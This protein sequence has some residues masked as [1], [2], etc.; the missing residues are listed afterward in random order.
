MKYNQI[1]LIVFLILI[2]MISACKFEKRREGEVV[3]ASEIDSSLLKIL[4]DEL[5]ILENVLYLYPV[6]GEIIEE[7]YNAELECKP[8][9]MNSVGKKDSYLGSRSQALNLGVYITDLAYTA[10]FG[11]TGEAMDYLEAVHSLY[12]RVG[13]ST[14]V[15]ESLMERA[16]ENINDSDSIVRVSNE[17][18]YQMI[19]FLE[20]SK[21]ENILAIISV[22]AYIESLYLVLETKDKFSEYDPVF[23]KISEMKYPL[24]NLLS[25]ARR[26]E[27]D[28]NVASIISYLISINETFEQLTAD[29][30]ETEVTKKDGKLVISGG[31][32]FNLTAENFKEMKSKIRSIRTEITAI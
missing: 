8:G 16:K 30:T 21:K 11:L 32:I 29:E 31:S 26:L 17:A 3:I 24:E 25:R 1:K 27:E 20:S 15:F 22:G 13:I 14:V 9:L 4:Q 6:P 18:F 10:K 23:A 28:K 7:F 5:N 2:Q 12:S 19:S